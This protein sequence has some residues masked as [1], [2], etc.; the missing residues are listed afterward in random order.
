MREALRSMQRL[1]HLSFVHWANHFSA[2]QQSQNVVLRSLSGQE[3]ASA[4][5]CGEASEAS[6]VGGGQLEILGEVCVG[7]ALPCAAL[8]GCGC[9]FGRAALPELAAVLESVFVVSIWMVC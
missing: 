9:C 7:S 6:A 8:L 2:R 4:G 5:A 3:S 1:L